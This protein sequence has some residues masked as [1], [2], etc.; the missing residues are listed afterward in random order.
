VKVR[1]V[2]GDVFSENE[3]QHTINLEIVP[4]PADG[5]DV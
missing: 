4:V 1:W 3:S 5:A 2:T